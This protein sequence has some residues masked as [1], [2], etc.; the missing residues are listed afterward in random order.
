MTGLSALYQSV[1]LEHNRAPRN[2]RAV[3]P[4]SHAADARNPLCGDWVH[5]ELSVDDADRITDVGFD[6]E[7]CAICRA[8]AS[9]MTETLTG[10]RLETAQAISE[11]FQRLVTDT[12]AAPEPESEAD[13]SLAAL[14]TLTGVRDYPMRV[15]CATLAWQAL[16]SAIG[17]PRQE[18]TE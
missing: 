11:R 12:E 10:R 5:L 7:G 14:W 8:S 9:I 2:Q 3:T 4:H 15:R 6:G 17:R 13:P 16:D 1:V 18:D